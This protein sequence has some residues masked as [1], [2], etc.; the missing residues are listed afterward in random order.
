MDETANLLDGRYRID[1]LLGEGATGTV[2]RGYDT[3]LGRSV[4][5]KILKSAYGRDA[6]IVERFYVEARMA[7]RIV[8]AHVVAMYDI[9]SDGRTHAIVMECVEGPSLATVLKEAGALEET[10]AIGFARQIAAALG[11]A[12]AQQLVH[13]D[14]KPANVLVNPAGVLKVTDFGLA[15]AFGHSDLTIDSPGTLVGSVHYFSPEQARGRA[16]GPPSDL[17]SLGI[18]LY[19]FC[20]GALPFT[21]NSAVAIAL[22]H[23]EAPAPTVADLQHGMSI[24]LARI[25]ARLLH[26][27][28]RERF[29]S[30][31]DLEIALARLVASPATGAGGSYATDAPTLAATPVG[32]PPKRQPRPGPAATNVSRLSSAR[33]LPG[34]ARA[35][36]IGSALLALVVLAFVVGRPK[37]IAIADVRGRSVDRARTSDTSRSGRNERVASIVRARVA[38]L[39]ARSRDRLGAARTRRAR[40]CDRTAEADRDRRRARSFR[41]SRANAAGREWVARRDPRESRRTHARRSRRRAKSAPGDFVDRGLDRDAHGEFRDAFARD[42]ELDRHELCGRRRALETREITRALCGCIRGCRRQFG[43]RADSLGGN[44]RASRFE[45]N[46]RHL[47][48]QQ[49]ARDRLGWRRRRRRLTA[50]ASV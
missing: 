46:R 37:P 40:N 4:A 6:E 1:A 25:V 31:N 9:V 47:D 44:A 22:A 32:V 41:R 36:A 17:Y 43:D 34:S 11:A 38:G 30:A 2:S 18:M 7:A 29:A 28:P 19:E 50:P 3:L 24:G 42:P 12:H 39:G 49:A 33:G 15:R 23:V 20:F 48:R 13:R 21:G 5:I 26:K 10:R 45:R 35:L 27:D 8:D 14:L 16:L